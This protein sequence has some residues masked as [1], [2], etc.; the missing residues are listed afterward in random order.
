MRKRFVL[1]EY[2]SGTC[3]YLGLEGLGVDLDDVRNQRGSFDEGVEG[4]TSTSTAPTFFLNPS[5][6]EL[7]ASD[8]ADRYSW[9]VP[10][11]RP[12]AISS[13]RAF[14]SLT[15]AIFPAMSAVLGV[16]SK[17]T[18]CA[19]SKRAAEIDSTA[20]GPDVRATS[21]PGRCMSRAA[22]IAA[23][24]GGSYPA[25]PVRRSARWTIEA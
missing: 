12:S 2:P 17:A 20:F 21:K 1:L 24:V 25:R 6:S 3:E 8:V 18:T 13:I 4:S 7:L 10:G 23:I 11:S 16:G 9:A 5:T 15:R 22:R 14:V 19:G